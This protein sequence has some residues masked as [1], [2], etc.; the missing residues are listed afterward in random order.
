MCESYSEH[1]AA[2]LCD[3]VQREIVR[4]QLS[5]DGEYGAHCRIEVRATHRRQHE[6]QHRQCATGRHGIAEELERELPA[7]ETLCHDARPDN[8]GR[9]QRT[10]NSFRSNA[11]SESG[12]C[13]FLSIDACDVVDC[14][15]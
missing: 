13:L 4:A 8:C 11:A 7:P 9:E 12:Q 2:D 10:A 15:L 6:D 5:A 3:H 1:S 14:A